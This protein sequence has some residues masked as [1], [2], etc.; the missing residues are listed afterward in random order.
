MYHLAVALLLNIKFLLKVALGGGV[1]FCFWISVGGS[2][3][4]Q[5]MK[6][7]KTKKKAHNQAL[8]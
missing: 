8:D 1:K 7:N 2:K 5:I 4:G 6:L 3:S